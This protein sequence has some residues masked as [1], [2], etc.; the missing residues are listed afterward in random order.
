[1]KTL[2]AER[3][4]KRRTVIAD[5]PV[6]GNEL[7]EEYLQ[8]VSGALGNAPG[9]R[10]IVMRSYAPVSSTFDNDSDYVQTDGPMTA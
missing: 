7:S 1:M 8:L 9:G 2:A 10:V 5:L 4:S 3:N 6:T